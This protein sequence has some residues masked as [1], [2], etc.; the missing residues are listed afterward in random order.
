MRHG[1]R[2]DGRFGVGDPLLIRAVDPQVMTVLSP[3]AVLVSNTIR[4]MSPPSR[5]RAEAA[6]RAAEDRSR[7]GAGRR[8]S[9]WA[10]DDVPFVCSRPASAGR[11]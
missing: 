9:S 10:I 11:T 7:N 3:G 4:P 2:R 5:R 6:S 8:R 1:V